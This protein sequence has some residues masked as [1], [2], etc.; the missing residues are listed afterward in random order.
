LFYIYLFVCLSVRLLVNNTAQNFIQ[1]NSFQD[2]ETK[3][4]LVRDLWAF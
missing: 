4:F 1:V 2:S 3:H